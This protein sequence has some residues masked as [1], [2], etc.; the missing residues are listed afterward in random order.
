MPSRERSR[1]L[2]ALRCFG[3]SV[4]ACAEALRLLVEGA[5]LLLAPSGAS[6]YA[7]VPFAHEK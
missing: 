1:V 7:I 6:T 4:S 2:G 3:A 5:D